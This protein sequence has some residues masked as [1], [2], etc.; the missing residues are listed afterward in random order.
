M[1]T[2]K[3]AAAELKVSV[4]RIHARCEA[5]S[6]RFKWIGAQ[7]MIYRDRLFY[8]DRKPGRPRKVGR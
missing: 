5:G 6:L 3:D 7:R 1:L 8:S 4:S 2:A